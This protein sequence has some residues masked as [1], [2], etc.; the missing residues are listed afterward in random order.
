MALGDILSVKDFG[1]PCQAMSLLELGVNRSE[2]NKFFEKMFSV[3]SFS[4]E[5]NND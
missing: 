1:A 2:N 5:K 3:G 4:L